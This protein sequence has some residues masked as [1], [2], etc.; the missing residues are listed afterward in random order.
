MAGFRIGKQGGENHIEGRVVEFGDHRMLDGGRGFLG[1]RLDG[2]DHLAEALEIPFARKMA[3]EKDRPQE[4]RQTL[5]TPGHQR[6]IGDLSKRRLQCFAMELMLV[7]RADVAITFGA[8]LAGCLLT[9][10]CHLSDPPSRHF[11]AMPAAGLAPPGQNPLRNVAL[12]SVSV[13]DIFAH[14]GERAMPALR[15]DFV[16]WDSPLRRRMIEEMTIRHFSPTTQQNYIRAVKNLADSF[17]HS[18]GMASTEDKRTP[19]WP[20][21]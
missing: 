20:L 14:G 18:P 2:G 9:A 12:P 8:A 10:L 7:E 4:F 15:H 19:W 1:E 16:E 13:T 6:H 21:L 3:G 17:G 11:D 5:V